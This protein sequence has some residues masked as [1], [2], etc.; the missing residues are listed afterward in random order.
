MDTDITLVKWLEHYDQNE[1]NGN[2]ATKYIIEFT[3][4]VNCDWLRRTLNNELE[5][6]QTKQKE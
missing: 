6:A 2:A 3:G 1:S 5:K 4:K